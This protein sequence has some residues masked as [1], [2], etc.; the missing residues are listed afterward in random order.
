MGR[1]HPESHRRACPCGGGPMNTLQTHDLNLAQIAPSRWQPRQ[2]FDPD[3]LKELASSIIDQGLINPVLVFLQN[4][5]Y[6]LIAGER[7]TRA[8]TA[9]TL[10]QLFPNVH[11]LRDWCAHLA[12]VGLT[13][14]GDKEY[15]ALAG[16]P[17]AKIRAAIYPA[18]DL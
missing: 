8:V 9:L 17:T 1:S 6:E 11:T 15:A 4:H 12:E 16:E 7:R 2:H 3:T 10:W 18:D 14:L 5:Q 13:G